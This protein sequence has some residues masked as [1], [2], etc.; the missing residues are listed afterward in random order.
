MKHSRVLY[1]N[2]IVLKGMV[3]ACAGESPVL[4]EATR[5]VHNGGNKAIVSWSTMHDNSVDRRRSRDSVA[6]GEL[7]IT[8]DSMK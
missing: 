4:I 5:N 7:S 2:A 6:R 3:H 1:W 8:A